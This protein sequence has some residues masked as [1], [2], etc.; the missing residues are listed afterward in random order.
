MRLNSFE[1]IGEKAVSRIFGT[2]NRSGMTVSAAST[3][4]SDLT[5]SLH[6]KLSFSGAL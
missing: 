3:P 5:T 4:A 2:D 1:E 6:D